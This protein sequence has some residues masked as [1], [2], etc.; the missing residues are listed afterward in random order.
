MAK[1]SVES[2]LSRNPDEQ[3]APK[4]QPFGRFSRRSFLS[5]L[6]AAGLAAT[7]PPVLA[8]TPPAAAIKD[9]V[10]GRQIAGAVPL[11]LKVNGRNIA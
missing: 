10:D 3:Q 8:G 5:H 9:D 2:G 4:V 6:G 1:D 7:A 11:T